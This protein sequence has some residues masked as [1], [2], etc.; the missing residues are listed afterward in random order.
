MNEIPSP[1]MKEDVLEE[2]RLLKKEMRG[3]DRNTRGWIVQELGAAESTQPDLGS[4]RAAFLK[5]VSCLSLARRDRLCPHAASPFF[6]GNIHQVSCVCTQNTWPGQRI[7]MAIDVP[8]LYQL[9]L[10]FLRCFQSSSSVSQLQNLYSFRSSSMDNWH[11]RKAW[12]KGF[13]DK[14]GPPTVCKVSRRQLLELIGFNTTVF[15][16]PPALAAQQMDMKEPEVIRQEASRIL[17]LASG[18]RVQDI[19]E[20]EGPEAREGD[21][22]EVNY[23][24]R[25]SNGYFV[26]STVDQFSGESTPVILTL[27]SKQIIQGL[28]EV[29]I[30]MKVGG[31]RRAFIPPSVGYINETLKPIP[32]EFGPRRS[33]LSHANETLVFELQLLK[34]SLTG[35]IPSSLGNLK[36]LESLDLSRNKLEGEI[37]QQLTNLTFL[38]F[39]NLSWNDLTGRI[40]TGYQ[41][42]TFTE[43]SFGGNKG[44]CGVPLPRNCRSIEPAALSPTTSTCNK[45]QLFG[46]D[47]DMVVS[48]FVVGVGGGAGGVV[49]FILFFRSRKEMVAV[50]LM[51]GE[52]LI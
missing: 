31:K 10:P 28:K 38:S 39:L 30:G 26:H 43:A 18:V 52:F 42:W 48:G 35:P 41:F 40:P 45:H 17:K 33:L 3:R 6:I 15:Y 7:C 16:V 12:V 20:G 36:Q 29:L 46:Y 14:L 27:D 5:H 24:C 47:W 13:Q 11:P 37:P 1:H 22:V 19:V 32:D 23:A 49:A 44:L 25:R 50:P 51:K 4:G 21:T 9:P 2:R 34:N 8:I